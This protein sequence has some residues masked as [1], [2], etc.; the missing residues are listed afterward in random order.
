[1]IVCD[2]FTDESATSSQ[3]STLSLAAL[4]GDTARISRV[5]KF[6]ESGDLDQGLSAGLFGMF[7]TESPLFVASDHGHA[8]TITA[9]VKAGA[10]VDIGKT[11]LF[12]VIGTKSA[13]SIACRKGHTKAVIALLE[14]GAD[15]NDE[16]T[17]GPFGVMVTTNSLGIASGFGYVEITAELLKAGA[18][19]NVG[20]AQFGFRQYVPEYT[21]NPAIQ[22]LL[23]KARAAWS[24]A[25][26]NPVKRGLKVEL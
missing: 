15:P 18:N 20:P 23:K 3:H 12:G 8:A 16:A 1:M 24:D 17:L 19:P 13:L 4:Y 5:A 25:G 14:A 9:L 11:N 7:A 26:D 21:Q 22:V 6:M 2:Q 10:D